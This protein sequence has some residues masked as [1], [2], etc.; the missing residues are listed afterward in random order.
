VW[1]RK[2]PIP[3]NSGRKGA[4]PV[5]VVTSASNVRTGSR[6]IVALAGTSIITGEG[7]EVT[8]QRTSVGGVTSD[9]I[10]C[11]SRM[12]GWSGG[13]SGVAG[14]GASARFL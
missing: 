1:Q 12:L 10:L 8:V 9:G 2:C 11:D 14:G 3:L 13:G 4:D 6:V 5:A 7:E